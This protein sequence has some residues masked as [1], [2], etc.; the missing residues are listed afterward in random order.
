VAVSNTII[1]F[2][3]LLTGGISALASM[4]STE[5]VILALSL[6]GG[7]YTSSKLPEVE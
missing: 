3:L 5:G 1:G 6:L 4:L 7:A 2:V